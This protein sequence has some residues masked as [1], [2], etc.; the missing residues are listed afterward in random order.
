MGVAGLL[1]PS[2][3]AAAAPCRALEYSFIADCMRSVGESGCAFHADRPDLGPQIAVWVESAD[4]ARFVDTLM[5]TNAIALFG[6]GNRPGEWDLRSGPRFP[7]GRRPMAL[8]VWAYGRGKTYPLVAMQDGKEQMLTY[9]EGDSSPEPHFCRPL[10]PYQVVDAITCPSGLFRSDKGRLDRTGT[11]VYPP[12]ADLL[13]FGSVCPFLPNQP[14]GSC[15]PGDSDRY[16]FLNDVDTVAAATPAFGAATGGAWIVPEAL[17]AGDYALMVEVGKEFDTNGGYEAPNAPSLDFEVFGTAGNIGQPSVV[18]RV[19]FTIGGADLPA[20]ATTDVLYG[21]GDLTGGTGTLFPPD[22]SISDQPGSGAGRLA[23]TVG[24]AGPGR[25]HVAV[26]AC[27]QTD[28]SS[29]GAPAPVPIQVPADGLMPTSARVTII[30]VADGDAPVVAY[31][32]RSAII[33]GHGLGNVTPDDFARWTPAPAVAPGAP[34]ATGDGSLTGL[35]PSSDYAVGV[36][37]HGRCGISPVS[38][39]RFRTPPIKYRQIQGCFV[40][41]AAFGSD[42]ASDVDVL[43]RLRDRAVARSGL[44]LLATDLYYAT[45]P[46]AARPLSETEVGKAL[47]RRPLRSIAA[48]GRVL[49][50]LGGR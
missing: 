35:V 31:D 14:N 5:V 21:F 13:D 4:R 50:E 1:L 49:L 7:Y 47:V 18:F 24:P 27:P 39:A 32:L 45:A 33:G 36:R 40:A 20:A 30:D 19:P 2:A 9:H 46:A 26:T 37:A 8:P 22:G 41:T 34:G 29:Q 25:V 16:A 42:L 38:Y 17:P 48:I 12:R 23:R 11:S 43:R 10:L 15:N 28:C 6:I 3:R 44:A